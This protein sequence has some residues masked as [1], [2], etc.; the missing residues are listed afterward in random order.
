[1]EGCGFGGSCSFS[2]AGALAGALPSRIL[3]MRQIAKTCGNS[4]AKK[5]AKQSLAPHLFLPA[6]YATKLERVKVCMLGRLL[7]YYGASLAKLLCRR[8]WAKMKGTLTHKWLLCRFQS[9]KPRS[10]RVK[11]GR[12]RLFPQNARHPAI[13]FASS[14][15]AGIQVRPPENQ[16][17]HEA[18]HIKSI[19]SGGFDPNADQ[20]NGFCRSSVRRRGLPRLFSP[21]SR[22]CSAHRREA[23]SA[24]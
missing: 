4:C 20:E 9:Y 8:P 2:G 21:P 14:P 11:A 19:K 10:C 18:S 24:A 17:K 7:L 23:A 16:P 1:M 15:F 5:H 6:N 13:R 22:R 12:P 3:R